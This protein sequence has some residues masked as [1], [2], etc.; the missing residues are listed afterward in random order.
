MIVSW[1]ELVWDEIADTPRGSLGGVACAVAAQLQEL[2]ATARLVS[3]VGSDAYGQRALSELE[4]RGLDTQWVEVLPGA[5]T[6]RVRVELDAEGPRYSALARLD[7]SRVPFGETLERALRSADAL[8]FALYIQGTTAPLDA[9]ERALAATR[10]PRWLGCDLNL[11]HAMSAETLHRTLTLTDFVKSNEAELARLAALHQVADVG[12]FLLQ[13]Y[14]NL[15]FVVETLGARG[16]RLV[17][18]DGTATFSAPLTAPAAN[19]LGA[20]DALMAALVYALVRG[21]SA[22]TALE[23]AVR[24]A[25]EHVARSSRG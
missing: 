2:G 10:R 14:E 18:R 25:S 7:W 20:G 24:Y 3:A 11:R 13:R 9:L 15:A 22:E 4:G 6:A 23:G 8:V 1:G 19:S 17:R 12:A 16:A 21:H 5:I